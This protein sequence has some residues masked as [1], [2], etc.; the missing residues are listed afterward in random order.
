MG[1]GTSENK[2]KKAKVVKVFVKEN[3]PLI[4]NGKKEIVK[5]GVQEL[6][7]EKAAILIDAGYAEPVE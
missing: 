6:P 4:I 1:T 3:T 2:P 5:K 7:P